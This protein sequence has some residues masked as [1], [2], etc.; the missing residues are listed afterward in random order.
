VKENDPPTR[1][2]FMNK[3]RNIAEEND[4]NE[5]FF[6]FVFFKRSLGYSVNNNRYDDY[7]MFITHW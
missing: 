7:R 4:K 5:S 3:E 1:I 2:N 6:S